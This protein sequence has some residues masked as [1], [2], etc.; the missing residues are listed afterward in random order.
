MG[1]R[2]MIREDFSMKP[3]QEISINLEGKKTGYLPL[4]GELGSIKPSSG[5]E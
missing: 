4:R 1:F 3:S 2:L 5:T